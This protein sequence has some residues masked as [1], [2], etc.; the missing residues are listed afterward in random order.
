[1][2]A[3]GGLTVRAA[4][5]AD[6]SF[7]HR[8]PE[9]PEKR[10]LR[11]IAEGEVFVAEVARKRVGLVRV[12]YLWGKTPLLTALWVEPKFRRRGIA[13]ALLRHVETLLARQGCP[14]LFSS[15]TPVNLLGQSWHTAVGF[16]RTGF[17]D[18]INNDGGGEFFFRKRVP[19]TPRPKGGLK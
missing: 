9:I 3:T 13:R 17:I 12:E 14:M 7:V 19:E 16:R 10:L 2:A 15:T 18:R 8:D 1:M 6:L 5:L 11:M 4:R